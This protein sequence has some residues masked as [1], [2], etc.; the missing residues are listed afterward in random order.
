MG[1][2]LGITTVRIGM[3]ALLTL[4]ISGPQESVVSLSLG[5]SL[6]LTLD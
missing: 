1:F 6:F 3:G 2:S 5:C 4:T